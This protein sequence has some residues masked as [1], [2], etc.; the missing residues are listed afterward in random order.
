MTNQ[1]KMRLWWISFLAGCVISAVFF[2]IAKIGVALWFPP[3][4]P[5][6]FFSWIIVV[7]LHGRDW[8]NG[9]NFA[10]VAAA[11][12]LFYAWCF[13][14]ALKA[15]LRSGGRFSKYFPE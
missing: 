2:A 3:F 11:N 9:Y 14:L 6:L 10:I 12:A 4:W 8:P 13:S 5:G 15:D 7:A 1:Q